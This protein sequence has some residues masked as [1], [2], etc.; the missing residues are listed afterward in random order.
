MILNKKLTT[1]HI[2]T[3]NYLLDT[4]DMRLKDSAIVI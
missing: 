3:I 2:E 4:A 1:F